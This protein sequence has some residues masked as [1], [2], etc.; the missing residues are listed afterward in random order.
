MADTQVA[1]AEEKKN[2]VV[3]PKNK[4]TDYSPGD[5]RNV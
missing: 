1:V 5:L 2:E 4:V 3:Q